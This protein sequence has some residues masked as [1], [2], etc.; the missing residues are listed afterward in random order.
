MAIPLG[1]TARNLQVIARWTLA[2]LIVVGMCSWWLPGY[3]LWGT[4][5]VGLL[6]VW[7]LWLCWKTHMGDRTMLL[8][9]MY[10]VLAGPAVILIYHMAGSVMAGPSDEPGGLGGAL[11]MSMILQF[12]LLALGVLVTQELMASV[13]KYIVVLSVCGAAMMAGPVLAMAYGPAD[14]CNGALGFVA[15]AGVAVWLTPLWTSGEETSARA[16]SLVSRPVR[17]IVIGLAVIVSVLLGRMVPAEAA[18][19]VCL[20]GVMVAL[21]ALRLAYRRKVILTVA[22]CVACI[23]AVLF[24]LASVP[25]PGMPIGWTN[26]LGRG[27][28]AFESISV[29]RTGAEVLGAFVGW[30][31]LALLAGGQALSA[32]YMLL[33][34]RTEG[35]YLGRAA[36]LTTAALLAGC[37]LLASGGFSIPSVT[38]AAAFTFG[39]LPAATGRPSKR[40][41][42]LALVVSFF[43]LMF[44]LGYVRH[45]GLSGWMS[46]ALGGDDKSLHRVVG[47]LASLALA[48]LMGAGKVR[49]GLLAVAMVALAGGIGE[50]LQGVLSGRSVQLQDWLAHLVGAGAALPLYLLCMAARWCES[51]DARPAPVLDHVLPSG[52]DR[53]RQNGKTD[54]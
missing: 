25:W 33:R 24:W 50:A 36:A 31:G 1:T 21:A 16:N 18:A 15:F 20:G 39:L 9:P 51:A 38:L 7:V 42:G 43:V 12:W 53:R 41:S 46:R 11:N 28:L 17:L 37:G 14:A 32:I 13:G 35:S 54:V 6:V 49:W 44:L 48:W 8:H 5:T 22:V 47:F 52:Q 30:V 23:F 26:I 40:I 10:A 29:N 19:S 45:G 4:L 34:R 2:A 27:E 3:R